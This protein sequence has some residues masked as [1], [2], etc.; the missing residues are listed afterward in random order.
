VQDAVLQSLKRVGVFEHRTVGALQAYLRESVMNHIRDVVRR[1][2]RRGVPEELG[3]NLPD[4]EL[5]A[6]ELAILR[7]RSDRFLE[8]LQR[9]RPAERQLIVWRIELGYSHT[10]I[11]ER[12]GKS[13]EAAGVSVRRALAR[14]TK[15]LRAREPER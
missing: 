4:P 13:K 9:L 14:L 15:E 8:A 6:D 7:E 1:V 2:R 11:G 10:E 3:D 12:L 5:P